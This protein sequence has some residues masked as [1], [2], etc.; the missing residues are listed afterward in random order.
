MGLLAA[1]GMLLS[2]LIQPAKDYL[3]YKT[4]ELSA[5]RELKLAQIQADKEAVI[6]GN[7]SD[8]NQRKNYLD[9]VTQQFRQGAII[10][11]MVPFC[12]SMIAPGY[13]KTMWTNFYDIPADF[14]QFFF[15]VY[16]VILGLPIAKDTLGQVVASVGRGVDAHREYKLEKR[17]IDRK[18]VMDIVRKAM[19]PKGMNQDQVAIFDKAL[20]AGE[21][22]E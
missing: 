20:D 2:N 14:R 19:F 15:I 22:A 10:F 4:Q 6:S 7:L 9:S 13:A 17:R 5:N 1:I 18:A 8:T 11:F 3:T 16:G 12:I 21:A